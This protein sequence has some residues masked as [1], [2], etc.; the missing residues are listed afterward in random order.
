LGQIVKRN[1][2]QREEI[3]VALDRMDGF[4]SAQDLHAALHEGGSRIG[5]TTVYRGLSDLAEEGL[6]DSL[7]GTDGVS[8][9]HPC[10]T[11]GRRH[12]HLICRACGRTVEV[13][14]A[15]TERTIRSAAADHGFTDP[16]PILEIFGL[17]AACSSA[18]ADPYEESRQQRVGR[19]CS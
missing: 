19:Q 5:L 10:H 4:V 11:Q 12:H 9:Y 15:E 14:M 18:A 16:S 1:T 17:C 2:R 8:R 3:R 7:R 6:A 13:E